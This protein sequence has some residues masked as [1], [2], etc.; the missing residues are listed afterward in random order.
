M[1]GVLL[2]VA[3][4]C[5]DVVL[6]RHSPLFS[7]SGL[8]RLSHSLLPH[9]E[10]VIARHLTVSVV[11]Y[12][13]AVLFI[14]M[15]ER[16]FPA[17]PNQKILSTGLLHDVLWALMEGVF[18]L[19][20]LNWFITA[21]YRVYAEHLS[22]LTLPVPDS[23]PVVV[24]LAIGAVALDL[25]RWWQHW[26]HH[27][28]TFLW[29]FHAVHHSQPEI[30]LFSNSRIHPVELLVS[31]ALVVLPMQMLHVQAPAAIWYMLL[32][33]W[34]GRFCHANIKTDFGPLRHIFVS[35]QS[36]RLHHSKSAEH[37]DQNYG[38]LLSVWDRLFGTLHRRYDEYPETGVDD[39][40]FPLEQGHSVFWV[41]TSP[42]RQ[43]LYPF[44]KLWIKRN[45]AAI[46]SLAA[47]SGRAVPSS[48]AAGCG[49]VSSG[50]VL[51]G[52][53]VRE[54][55]GMRVHPSD[56]VQLNHLSPMT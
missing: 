42:I 6:L 40:N 31:S 10:R 18:E 54:N 20:L 43:L 38:A 9:L 1:I 34:H 16:R 50:G 23:M 46:A 14:F 8:S 17:V 13:I 25:M 41:V 30:N 32:M 27:R 29:P 11:V 19:V 55:Q 3:L 56:A 21:L 36:H 28:L 44:T 26:V 22:F 4:G 52:G 47:L 12:P 7:A 24:R 33:T 49:S 35:P 37:F 51:S 15:L 45:P 5:L 48:Q 53:V 39:A 2:L